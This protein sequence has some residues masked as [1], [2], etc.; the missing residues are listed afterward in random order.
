MGRREQPDAAY[1]EE[2]G[3]N[4]IPFGEGRSENDRNSA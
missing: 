3:Y 1:E 4:T 2:Y